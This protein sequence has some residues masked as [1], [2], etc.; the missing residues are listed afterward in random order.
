MQEQQ[1]MKT[2]TVE[3]TLMCERLIVKTRNENI[4]VANT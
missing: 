2:S 3:K 1:G 4:T